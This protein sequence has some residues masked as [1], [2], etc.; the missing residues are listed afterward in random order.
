V[1]GFKLPPMMFTDEEA[2]ALSIGLLASREL[3]VAEMIPAV[4]SPGRSSSA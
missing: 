3:G 4:D 2:I 1:A